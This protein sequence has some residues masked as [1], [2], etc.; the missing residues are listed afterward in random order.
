MCF[1]TCS[2][3]LPILSKQPFAFPHR[4]LTG[5]RHTWATFIEDLI[6]L[7][8]SGYIWIAHDV[9][10]EDIFIKQ[11]TQRLEDSSTLHW[12][13]N[14]NNNSKEITYKH[15]KSALTL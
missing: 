11:F 13:S 9:G 2:N 8:G 4:L 7:Y 14:I 15:L 12:I 1:L 6:Y 10:N 3:Q 5:G